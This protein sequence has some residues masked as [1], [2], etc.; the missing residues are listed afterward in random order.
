MKLPP[1][2]QDALKTRALEHERS[3]E[4]E[5]RALL[6]TALEPAVTLGGPPLEQLAV[7]SN[8]QL[9]QVAHQ[10]VPKEK[11]ERMQVLID[12]LKAEGLAPEASEEVRRLQ[13][14]ARH[15]MLLRAEA[16]ALLRRRGHDV[17]DVRVQL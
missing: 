15:V 9:W 8:E 2:L 5:A 17:S 11:S 10:Q 13:A 16:S 6:E 12:R 7:L 14:Y 3:V 4:E 1:T